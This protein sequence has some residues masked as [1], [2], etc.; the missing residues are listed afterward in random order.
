MPA[1]QPMPW[2]NAFRRAGARACGRSADRRGGFTLVELLVVIAIIGGL[3]ALLLPAVQ[4]ARES[5]RN[6]TC[7]NQIKQIGLAF[8]THHENLKSFPTGGN[9]WSTPPTYNG[10]SPTIG[11]DQDA[12][13]AFQ[14]LP[15]MEATGF[16]RGP[17][18]DDKSKS[19][20]AIAVTIPLYFCP[21]RRG[22]QTVTHTS[23]QTYVAPTYTISG[24]LVHGLIDYAGSN[25]EGTG[26]L[27]R[28]GNGLKVA[29][30]SMRD[31]SDGASRTLAVAEKRL[32]LRELGS[33][34]PDDKE[35]YTSG[36]DDDTMRSTQA[37]KP[38]A[39]DYV[40]P[41]G[42]GENLFGS[43][44]PKTFNAV[45]ADGSV[46]GLSYDIDSTVFESLGIINDGRN[47]AVE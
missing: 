38:P 30:R 3:I 26:I 11:A 32:N 13:W 35:G 37:D 12:S 33:V 27:V 14:I 7:K 25:Y 17:A 19:I 4:S 6:L 1:C 21:T 31:L 46:H 29:P 22:P 41:S 2:F 34:Q 45:F 47:V 39:K 24:E 20:A 40:G 23:S 36:F 15:Y 43:S 18:G 10:G 42:D 5:S 16:W 9:D 8:Q 28:S 44:H